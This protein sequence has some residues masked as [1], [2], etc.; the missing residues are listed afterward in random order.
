MAHGD[1]ESLGKAWWEFKLLAFAQSQRLADWLRATVDRQLNSILT[2]CIS[3]SFPV[4]VKQCYVKYDSLVKAKATQTHQ[5]STDIFFKN[6]LKCFMFICFLYLCVFSSSSSW[7]IM[8]RIRTTT[9]NSW[10]NW[11]RCG[12]WVPCEIIFWSLWLWPVCQNS[13][14]KHYR[15]NDIS[16]ERTKKYVLLFLGVNCL[17][18]M[19][20]GTNRLLCCVRSP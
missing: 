10:R 14:P 4:C 17:N 2:T 5:S 13:T 6:L 1:W 20:T 8:E 11:R 15:W 3:W 18:A 7:R 19:L 9:M 16:T 12:R